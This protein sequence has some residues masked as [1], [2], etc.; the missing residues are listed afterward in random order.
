MFLRQILKCQIYISFTAIYILTLVGFFCNSAFGSVLGSAF[1]QDKSENILDQQ[2]FNKEI[3]KP[4]IYSSLLNRLD[5]NMIYINNHTHKNK[6]YGYFHNIHNDAI[7]DKTYGSFSKML[8]ARQYEKIGHLPRL[9]NGH[10]SYG[11]GPVTTAISYFR[12]SQS[13]DI[14]HSLTF[15]TDYKFMPGLSP[16][17]EISHFRAK[18]NK[19][20]SS[21][22]PKKQ[23]KGTVALIGAKLSF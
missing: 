16:Y 11:L 23:V 6:D 18:T 1:Y 10:I 9:Y 3:D 5:F 8:T 14:I 2:S 7:F 12:A 4:N 13:K 15:V 19:N 21:Q 20:L 22:S 17:I